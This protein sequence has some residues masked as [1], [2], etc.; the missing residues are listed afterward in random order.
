[1]IKITVLNDNRKINDEFVTEGKSVVIDDGREVEYE[2]LC[3]TCYF[4]KVLKIK[5]KYKN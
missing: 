4:E 5:S 3:G 2:S 1:M